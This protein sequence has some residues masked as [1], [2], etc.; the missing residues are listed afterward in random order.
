MD[1]LSALL[2]A[3]GGGATRQ[4]GQQFGLNESQ[5]GS[6]LSALVPALAA[7]LQRNTSSQGGLQDLIGALSGG[8][9]QQYLDNPS[10]L[11]QPETVQ[12]GN[13]ILGHIFGSKEVSR[14]VASRASAQ[15]GISPDILKA[16]LPLVASMMMG[17]L[18]KQG[19]QQ[20]GGLSAGAGGGGLLDMLSPMLD[21][22]RDGSA[23]DDVL[24]SLGKMLGGR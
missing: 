8:S 5:V 21:S 23:I 10:M 11:G 1:I 3:Q 13:G 16:M 24:G 9:H 7:G 22:N 12:D 4:L 15:S 20:P 18:S 6:A 19:A 17:A 2:A 14:E